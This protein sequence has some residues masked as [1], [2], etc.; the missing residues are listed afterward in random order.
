MYNQFSSVQSLRN[1][2][3]FVTP[4]TAAG[5]ASRP[6]PIFGGHPNPCPSSRWCHSTISSSVVHFSSC[7]RSFPALGSFLMSQLFASGSQSIGVSASVSD[8]PMPMNTQDWSALGW[9]GWISS[10]SKGLQKFTEPRTTTKM[11]FV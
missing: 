1:V 4:W 9:T 3:L 11:F 10:Q 8:L 6:T 7:L 2:R 5:Q